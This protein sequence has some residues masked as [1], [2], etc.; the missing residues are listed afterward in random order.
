MTDDLIDLASERLGGSVLYATDDYFAEKENLLRQ[1]KAV[2]KEHEYTDRGKWMDGWESRRKRTP[3]HDFAIIRL[4]VPGI[5]RRVVVDTAFFRGNFPAECSIEGCVATPETQVDDLP[6]TAGWI[7]IL[8]RSALS[9]DSENVFDGVSP[10][11]FTHLRLHIYPD[12][13]VAR[14]RALGHAVPDWHREGGLSADQ[15]LAAIE[16]G[17]Q[18]LTCSDM[19]FGPKHNLIMP[20][21][22]FNMSDGWETRRRRGPGHDWVIV[23]LAAEAQLRRVEI[24]TS[25]FKGNFP[26]TFSLDARAEEGDWFEVI[27]RT[28]LL[29]HTRHV[30]VDELKTAGPA[31]QVRLNVY[32]DGGVARLRVWGQATEAGRGAA[33]TK[34]INS[35]IEALLQKDL[36]RC[37]ASQPWVERMMAT[38]PFPSWD[39][40]TVM[41]DRIWWS[42]DQD[43]WLDAF[44]AHPRIGERVARGWSSQEQ[45]RAAESDPA[46]LHELYETNRDYE[47]RFGHIFIVCATGKTA[48][49]M[50]AI[51]QER[52]RNS[53]VDELRAAAEEQRKITHL[54]LLKL[55]E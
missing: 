12:G 32:P 21:R 14:F 53:P 9:G 54:R 43:C 15:D 55:V 22:S 51:I 35:R 1:P 44:K 27:E 30:F 49:E 42:L 26:D 20:G 33:V 46:V 7:E 23:Q 41:A 13:G 4:G 8:P 36:F 28:K 11:A 18:V 34:L 39:A 37:C 38:R 5:I 47:E 50:L 6:G 3:G 48:P 16:H 40:V 19:F 52:M 10:Y 45:A 17:G 29:P 25:H 24:D 2:W 31:H